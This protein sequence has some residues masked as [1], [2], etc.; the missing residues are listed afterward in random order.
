MPLPL[1]QDGSALFVTVA[2]YFTPAGTDI[3]K[4]GIFPD[5]SC[6]ISME[7]RPLQLSAGVGEE[8]PPGLPADPGSELVSRGGGG[9]KGEREWRVRFRS[10]SVC[11]GGAA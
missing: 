5:R 10:E 6:G 8:L 1:P 4:K 7:G 9:A 2:K 3:D 11:G